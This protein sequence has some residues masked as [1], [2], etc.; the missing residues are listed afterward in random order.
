MVLDPA[1]TQGLADPV[2]ALYQRAEIYLIRCI[3]DALIRTGEAPSWAEA[4]LL[5]IRQERGNVEGMADALHRRLGT[6]WRDSIETAYLRGQIEAEKELATIPDNVLP[7]RPIPQALNTDAV[8]ALTAEAIGMMTPVHQGI[9]RR[10]ED[11]WRSIV[12]EATGYSV[13]G[14]MTTYQAAKNAFTRMVREGLPYFQDRRGRKWGLDTYAEMAVRTATNKALIAGHTDT[15]V[16][17]GIDL[18]VVSSH[19]NPAPQCAPFERKVLSLTGQFAPGTHRIGDSIVNV[20][21]TMRDAEASGLHHP[22][23]RHTHSAYIP[24]YTRVSDVPYDGDDS[25]YK[26]TQKQRYLERQIRASKRMEEAA[27]DESDVRAARQRTRAYQAKLR[28]HI[29]EYDLPRR[30][31]REQVRKPDNGRLSIKFD[32][33]KQPTPKPKPVSSGGRRHKRAGDG[34]VSVADILAKNGKVSAKSAG[35]KTQ[36]ATKARKATKKT[37]PKKTVV[38]AQTEVKL[39]P[40]VLPDPTPKATLQKLPK[41][42]RTGW[43]QIASEANGDSRM[44]CARVVNAVEMRRRG[45]DV[46]AHASP[47]LPDAKANMEIHKAAVTA[48][49]NAVQNPKLKTQITTGD[50][51]MAAWRTKDGKSRV[52]WQSGKGTRSKSANKATVDRFQTDM[53]EGASGFVAA[54][55]DGTNAGH[56]WNWVKQDGEIRFYD[57]QQQ[58][59]FVNNAFHLLSAKEGTLQMVR[60]DDLIPTDDVIRI[61]NPKQGGM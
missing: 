11:I 51:G 54:Q 41:T 22:N 48:R 14:S 52:F 27:I 15:M 61:V 6:T 57:A 16:Q 46:Q 28:D 40:P 34:S 32:I 55:I 38:L 39:P 24:G 60:V 8:Y 7:N 2:V 17:H 50:V 29:E 49:R 5:M 26:A 30:R 53:P 21:A 4:Q 3:R 33:P 10:T 12:A 47:F 23:C 19:K 13:T 35:N 45:Y 36:K 56:I 44:N 58:A 42:K 25:G 1:R 37:S 31:H 9:L 59:G 18:V 20:R 43:E